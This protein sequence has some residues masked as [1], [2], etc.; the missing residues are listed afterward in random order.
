MRAQL[1]HLLEATRRRHIEIMVLP[2]GIGAHASP[3]GAFDVFRMRPP[4]P[5]AGCIS[6]GRNPCGRRQQG[7]NPRPDIRSVTRCGSAGKGGHR[8]P[9]RSGSASG[10]SDMTAQ[11][12]TMAATLPPVAWHV[13]TRSGSGGGNCVEAGPVLDGSG[14]VAVRDSKDRAGHVLLYPDA[15]WT[16]F[17]AGL[18]DGGFAPPV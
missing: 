2:A 13:S 15:A 5:F 1:T 3:D 10:V 11:Q 7:R 17:L 12:A 4:Y 6:T 8:V 14:R 9:V 16:T 18:R